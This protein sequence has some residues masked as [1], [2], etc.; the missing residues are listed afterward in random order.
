MWLSSN[1]M[2]ANAGY[3]THHHSSQS[4]QLLTDALWVRGPLPVN[5]STTIIPSTK[6]SSSIDIT[7]IKTK[8]TFQKME[9]H[10]I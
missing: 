4:W 8:A 3:K 6:V 1:N 7:Q 10:F 5:I 2:Y 9:I